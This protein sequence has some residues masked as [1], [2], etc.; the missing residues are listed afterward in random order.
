MSKKN[1]TLDVKGDTIVVVTRIKEG[2]TK[3]RIDT[4][5]NPKED[6]TPTVVKKDQVEFLVGTNLQIN[7][8]EGMQTEGENEVEIVKRNEGEIEK[9]TEEIEIQIEAENLEETEVEKEIDAEGGMMIAEIEG[10]SINFK[11]L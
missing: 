2:I 1:T 3:G 11:F 10:N 9:W 7:K 4:K 8:A 5:K 6:T